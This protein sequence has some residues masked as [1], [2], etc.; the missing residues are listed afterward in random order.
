[1]RQSRIG[2]R[3]GERR[4]ARYCAAE[5]GLPMNQPAAEACR[6]EVARDDF[7]RQRVVADPAAPALRPLA[8][9]EVRLRIDRF[10]LTANNVTYAAFGDAMHYWD[11]FPAAEPG[12]G[13]IPVWGFADVAESRVPGV[14]VGERL[15]GYLPMGRFLVV[16]PE[17]ITAHGFVDGSAHRR[18]LPPV[19]NQLVRCAADPAYDAAREA[20]QALLTPLFTTSFLIDD[21]LAEAGFFGARQLLLSSAS[22]KTAYAA[23]FCLARRDGALPVVGCTSPGRVAFC[24]ALGVYAEVRDYAALEAADPAVPTVY[25]D[26]SGDADFRRR[27]HRHYREALR[28]SCSVGGTHWQALGGGRDL[29]GPRPELFFAPTQIQRRASP[30]PEGWGADGFRQR[31]GEARRAFVAKV[32]DPAAPWLVVR[33]VRGVEAACAALTDLIDGRVDARDGLMVAL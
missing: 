33:P 2:P 15:Y 13:C 17:R 20:E 19:Y 5:E 12:W 10:A 31:L 28:Y 9:G 27:V 16:R 29:P 6:I 24:R 32:A 11:F 21:F 22:S 3:R 30:P 1:V 14:A 18:A 26:F 25:V 7:R 8:D 23:A 4:R